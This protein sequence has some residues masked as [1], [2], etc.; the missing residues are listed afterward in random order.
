MCSALNGFFAAFII[1]GG[2]PMAGDKESRQILATAQEELDDL[3]VELAEAGLLEEAEAAREVAARAGAYVEAIGGGT[4]S[5]PSDLVQR[6]EELAQIRKEF[7][8]ALNV[9]SEGV[10]GCLSAET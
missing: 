1:A 7:A 6:Q 5:E 4:K 10:G 3:A 9:L 8:P 2:R